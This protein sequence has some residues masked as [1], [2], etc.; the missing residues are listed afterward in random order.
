MVLLERDG[1]ELWIDII[2]VNWISINFDQM[3]K[4]CHFL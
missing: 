3:K 4:L 2:S 1:I